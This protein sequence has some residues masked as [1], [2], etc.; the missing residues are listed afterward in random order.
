M[1]ND[2]WRDDGVDSR[3]LRELWPD[4]LKARRNS[5]KDLADLLGDSHDLAVLHETLTASPKAFGPKRQLQTV[6]GLME[7]RDAE[8]LARAH[9]L[10]HRLF[11]DKPGQ[12][13]SR[14]EDAWQAAREELRSSPPFRRLANTTNAPNR[15]TRI[16]IAEVPRII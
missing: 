6:L 2:E 11:A 5:L 14:W 3:L 13:E 12:L 7:R 16:V 1:V 8:L 15:S 4:M 9:P 10:G